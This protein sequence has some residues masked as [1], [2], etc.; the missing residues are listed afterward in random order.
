MLWG[1]MVVGR[2]CYE[3]AFGTLFLFLSVTQLC[4]GENKEG[5]PGGEFGRS[6]DRLKCLHLSAVMGFSKM[7]RGVPAWGEDRLD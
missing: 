6:G 3:T 2:R 7:G 1:R 5:R 4:N